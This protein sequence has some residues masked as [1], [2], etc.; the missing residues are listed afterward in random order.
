M[1]GNPKETG[2]ERIIVNNSIFTSTDNGVRIKTW[3][4]PS[5]AYATNIVF[6]N[7]EMNNVSN[8]IIIDQKY[9]PE[10]NCAKGVYYSCLNSHFHTYT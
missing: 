8:P 6:Q 10:R 4:K 9:C 1:G 2:V 3:A 7:L 5:D